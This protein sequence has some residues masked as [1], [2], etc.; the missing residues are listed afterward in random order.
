M[1]DE[2][3]CIG[4]VVKEDSEGE[5]TKVVHI[6]KTAGTLNLWHRRL[7]HLNED[8]VLHL[9]QKGMVEGMEITHQSVK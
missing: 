2:H 8:D 5:A 9:Y 1:N 6:Q 7:V 4:H 3:A